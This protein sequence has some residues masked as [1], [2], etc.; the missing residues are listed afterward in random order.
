MPQQPKQVIFKHPLAIRW[1]HWLNFPILACM[2]WSGLLIYWANDVYK[3]RIANKE[4]RRM[5]NSPQCG[6]ENSSCRVLLKKQRRKEK[7]HTARPPPLVAAD[8]TAKKGAKVSVSEVGTVHD[9]TLTGHMATSVL[10]HG[11]TCVF[12][13]EDGKQMQCF[14]SPSA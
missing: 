13:T 11:A 4:V 8:L 2:I 12:V 6:R 1:F 5:K 14:E 9:G 3:I 10:D 7:R